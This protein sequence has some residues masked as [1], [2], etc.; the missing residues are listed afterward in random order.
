MKLRIVVSAGL[1]MLLFLVSSFSILGWHVTA[2]APSLP[3]CSTPTDLSPNGFQTS[4]PGEESDPGVTGPNVYAAWS[5]NSFANAQ[6]YISVSNNNGALFTSF[7]LDKTPTHVDE[8]PR[9]ALWRNNVYV[10]WQDVSGS[11]D[12]I[13]FAVSR[14]KGTSF[15]T[16]IVLGTSK[17]SSVLS[18]PDWWLPQISVSSKNVYVDWA[19]SNKSQADIY[20]KVSHDSG[21]TFQSVATN[22]SDDPQVSQ[23]PTLAASGNNVYASWVGSTATSRGVL[24]IASHD[25]G[26]IFSKP[27]VISNSSTFDSREPILAAAGNDVY[28]TWRDNSPSPS[29]FDIFVKAS[30]DNGTSFPNPKVNVSHDPGF[31]REAYI[32]ASGANVYVIW[33]DQNKTHW[34]TLFSASNDSGLTFLKPTPL[35]GNSGISQNNPT[36]DRPG[37]AVSGK[38]VYATWDDNVSGNYEVFFAASSNNGVSFNTPINVSHDSGVSNLQTIGASGSIAYV[39]WNDNTKGNYH[40]MISSCT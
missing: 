26:S 22:L 20:F 10:V 7:V 13:Y 38:N 23:E 6:V 34:N 25:N 15:S 40:V 28:V 2:Q 21:K 12:S 14:N 29:N 31:S 5:N 30:N 3:S 36:T 17:I 27:I 24:F 18:D 35:G 32:T 39:L 8:N 33:K 4:L 16:P 9:I 37:L 19:G 1:I 11:N